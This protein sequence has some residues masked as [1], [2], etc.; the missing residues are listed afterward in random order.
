MDNKKK[1]KVLIIGIF[2]F[3]AIIVAVI[4]IFLNLESEEKTVNVNIIRDLTT[5]TEDYNFQIEDIQIE[6][7]KSPIY[8]CEDNEIPSY[9][10]T[11]AD[12]I[13]TDLERSDNGV[14][15]FWSDE[16]SNVLTYDI[17]TTFLDIDLTN[18][19]K[20]IY[21]TSIENFLND[22]LDPSIKY[23][24]MNIENIGE[25]QIYTGNRYINGKEIITGFGVS[26]YY[27]IKGGYLSTARVLLARIY[28]TDFMTKLISDNTLLENYLSNSKYPKSMVIDT[29]KLYTLDLQNY[30]DFTAT[31]SY[32]SCS[33][34]QLNP[35]LYFSLCNKEYIYDVY[36]ISG[37]CDVEYDGASVT[38]PFRGFINAVDPAYVTVE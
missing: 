14:L 20:A 25:N 24:N 19:P 36:A 6:E 37:T 8:I 5:D 2:L 18:Y 9:I 29:A 30:E 22:F 27:Y 26:D 35:K 11:L 1:K 33:I 15:V 31:I 32:D 23:E 4:L 13:N 3:I 34:N 10:D 38:V 7:T 21:I 16:N 17:N 12:I 28:A